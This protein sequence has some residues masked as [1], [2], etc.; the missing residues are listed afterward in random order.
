METLS[1]VLLVAGIIGGILA[2]AIYS[3]RNAA[4]VDPTDENFKK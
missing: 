4:E 3:L 2:L 1:I